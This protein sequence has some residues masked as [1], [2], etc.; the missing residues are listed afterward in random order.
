MTEG[1]LSYLEVLHRL[2]GRLRLQ[3][4]PTGD[5]ALHHVVEEA[6]R[7]RGTISCAVGA[8]GRNLVVRF[9]PDRVSEETLLTRLALALS[10]SR[11]YR[12]VR[13]IVEQRE[14]QLSANAMAAGIS[15]G[16]AS[17]L[18]SAAPGG[19]LAGVSGWVAALATLG[20]VGEGVL[21]DLGKG[22][23]RPEAMAMVHLLRRLGSPSAGSG[24]LLAWLLYFGPALADRARGVRPAA[25]ELRPVQM[26][27]KVG[28][29]EEGTHLEIVT[30]PVKERGAAEG[31][32]LSPATIISAVLGALAHALKQRVARRE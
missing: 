1:A 16:V 14:K 4:Q 28:E 17:F 19:I 31:S 27:Q 20:A 11:G 6:G 23:P 9:D 25:V 13:L 12:P 7:L 10:A 5:S 2:P 32:L 29:D 15:A 30:R 3:V 8:S 22:K 21:K 26:E 24:A 18:G